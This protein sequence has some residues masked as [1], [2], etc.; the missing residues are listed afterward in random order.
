MV[1]PHVVMQDFWMK[2]NIMSVG[3]LMEARYERIAF[4]SN[5]KNHNQHWLYYDWK[6]DQ[7]FYTR[8]GL[9]WTI[10]TPLRCVKMSFGFVNSILLIVL[11]KPFQEPIIARG[12]KLRT[13]F[14][15]SKK[16]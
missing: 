2:G 8:N 13:L 4:D 15:G 11:I 3:T 14:F 7:E 5:F 16:Q 10:E 12:N 1:T 9:Y 6:G